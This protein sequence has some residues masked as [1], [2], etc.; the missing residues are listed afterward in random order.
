MNS[1]V[2][3]RNTWAAHPAVTVTQTVTQLLRARSVALREHLRPAVT[4]A[5]HSYRCG[6]RN[7]AKARPGSP[8][9]LIDER[10]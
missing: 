7:D 5:P 6:A 4:P 2:R 10:N 1:N 9:N 8:A 3:P